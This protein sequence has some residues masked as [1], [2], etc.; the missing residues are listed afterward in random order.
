MPFLQYENA[1]V[2][3]YKMKLELSLCNKMKKKNF[4]S[5]NFAE[6]LNISIL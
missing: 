5:Q 1:S 4:F 6:N 2:L 3:F